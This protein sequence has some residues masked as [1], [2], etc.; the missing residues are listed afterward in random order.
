MIIGNNC[1]KALEPI[2]VI[3]SKDGG[4]YAKRTRLGWCVSAPA[5]EEGQEVFVCNRI[6]VVGEPK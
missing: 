5:K 6:H 4:P 1:P 2:E 3:A